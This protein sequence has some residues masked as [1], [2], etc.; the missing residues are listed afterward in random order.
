MN[1]RSLFALLLSIL[2][3]VLGALLPGIVAKRQDAAAENHV[4]FQNVEGIQ[5]EF[6]QGELTM[7]DTLSM[8]ASRR[9]T[10]EIPVELT[11]LKQD[12]LENTVAATAIRYQQAGLLFDEIKNFKLTYSQSLLVYGRDGQSNIFWEV[13][14][15]SPDGSS[16]FHMMIDDRTGALCSITYS[17]AEALYQPED[18]EQLMSAFV[19][20]YLSGLGE[21]FYDYSPDY[22]LNSSEATDE[23]PE[24]GSYVSAVL[25]L[26]NELYGQ[27][28]LTFLVNSNGF[29]TYF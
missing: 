23:T 26:E 6:V 3:I 20:L 11:S 12:K 9:E 25:S 5:L 21:E 4:L 19:K 8:L 18:M 24:K 27:A 2:M 28:E 10:V 22:I 17:H 7:S 13:R 14:Y 16:E 29:R 1:R 15:S